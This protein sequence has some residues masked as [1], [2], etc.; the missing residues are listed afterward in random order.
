MDEI[1][2]VTYKYKQQRR[3]STASCCMY[4]RYCVFV[5]LVFVLCDRYGVFVVLAMCCVI[6]MVLV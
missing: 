1:P 4:R 2:S 5:V 3:V 6:V